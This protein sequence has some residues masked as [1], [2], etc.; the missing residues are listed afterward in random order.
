MMRA[1]KPR[2]SNTYHIGFLEDLLLNNANSAAAHR[3][4]ITGVVVFGAFL[5]V[6]Q[7]FLHLKYA[8]RSAPIRLMARAG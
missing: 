5:V 7:R 8:N 1:R 4:R 3:V 2:V 6:V